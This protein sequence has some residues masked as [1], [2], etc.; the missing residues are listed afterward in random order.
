[1]NNPHPRYLS[2]FT[3]DHYY[4]L[5][6]SWLSEID[7]TSTLDVADMLWFYL[8]DGQSA[9]TDSDWALEQQ[10]GDPRVGRIV[11]YKDPDQVLPRKSNWSMPLQE[12]GGGE[13][14]PILFDRK[15]YGTQIRKLTSMGK[16]EQYK[17]A[18]ATE[19]E[20][21]VTDWPA[22]GPVIYRP[23]GYLKNRWPAWFG[24]RNWGARSALLAFMYLLTKQYQAQKPVDK[25]TLTVT[26]SHNEIVQTALALCP[27][28]IPATNNLLSKKD[29][30]RGLKELVALG[31]ITE[32]SASHY[33]FSTD[34][35]Q[36]PHRWRPVHLAR[37]LDLDE[38][39]LIEWLTL[40]AN[41]MQAL[42]QPI[43]VAEKSWTVLKKE[44]QRKSNSP[45][46]L[47]GN[48][49]ALFEKH[50]VL[51]CTAALKAKSGQAKGSQ[52]DDEPD[53]Q[54][55]QKNPQS[56]PVDQLLQDFKRE[57]FGKGRYQSEYFQ[58]KSSQ[59]SV[60]KNEASGGT[61]IK[62]PSDTY[63]GIQATQLVIRYECT[64]NL[65]T[66]EALPVAQGAYFIVTQQNEHGDMTTISIGPAK[67]KERDI[68]FAYILPAN[69]LHKDRIDYARPFEV[70]LRCPNPDPRLHLHCAF[71]L[72]Y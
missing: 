10:R 27:A 59:I 40:A 58:F 12:S 22:V 38:E 26:V 48:D 60:A 39:S 18:A 66:D 70:M 33:C 72:L 54:A 45:H 49:L 25:E 56:I 44:R 15:T 41:L 50:V 7:A 57:A 4:Y 14:L 24:A 16:I 63:R 13:F 31:L 21:S 67:P 5:P 42:Q 23:I 32:T 1:M 37:V 71:V 9:A 47:Y 68:R 20:F 65:S 3:F 28:A 46:L 11:F 36:V 43:T 17:S 61:Q 2:P 52:A 34:V 6:L 35:L 8:E 53:K 19:I 30:Q 29:V 62:M 64:K 69:H 51:R 55:K